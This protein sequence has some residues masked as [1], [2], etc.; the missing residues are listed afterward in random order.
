MAATDRTG[1]STRQ[2]IAAER[3]ASFGA[4]QR[5]LKAAAASR[6][7]V[8]AAAGDRSARSVSAKLDRSP[9]VGRPSKYLR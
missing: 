1:T 3:I 5:R 2:Q 4:E 9:V 7:A 6:R 8:A